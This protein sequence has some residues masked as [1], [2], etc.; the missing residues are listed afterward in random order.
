MTSPGRDIVS[1]PPLPTGH[2]ELKHEIEPSVMVQLP[3]AVTW[4]YYQLAARR[5]NLIQSARS[6]FSC[7]VTSPGWNIVSS[8]P[9]KMNH[10]LENFL[11]SIAY[12]GSPVCR[13]LAQLGSRSQRKSSTDF[14]SWL[15]MR[16]RSRYCTQTRTYTL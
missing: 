13:S 1:G 2:Q 11:L 3:G 14:L 9:H 7:L 8:H 15:P 4:T 10:M 16:S 12:K 5:S 6:V